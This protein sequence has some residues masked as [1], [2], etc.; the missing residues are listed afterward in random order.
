MK[1]RIALALS[2]VTLLG[3]AI[4]YAQ[5]MTVI[6]KVNVPF[7][8]TVDKKELPAGKYEILEV[9][10]RSS[11][12][13]LR[14]ADMKTS[15]YLSVIERLAETDP[16]EKHPPRVVFDS[17]GDQKLFSEFWP[18]NNADGYL[19]GTIKGEHKHIVLE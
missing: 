12:L 11:T 4:V 9:H 14:S 19:V 1:K 2:F 3:A 6:G 10:G 15:I 18:A 16:S 8:F 5:G 17:A 13:L 7:K